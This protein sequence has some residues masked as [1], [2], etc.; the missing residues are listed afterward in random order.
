[1]IVYLQERAILP[2]VYK[3]CIISTDHARMERLCRS[4]EI[5]RVLI[6]KP[7]KLITTAYDQPAEAM[8][9]YASTT[10]IKCNSLN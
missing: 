4:M 2:V 5:N 7:L 10:Q 9:D 8:K 3:I 6:D 1:M